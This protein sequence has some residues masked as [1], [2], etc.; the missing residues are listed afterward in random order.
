VIDLPT[1]QKK[2]NLHFSLTL[3]LFGN[4]IPTNAANAYAGVKGR[5][6][7]DKLSDDHQH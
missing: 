1:I 6:Q 2:L 4:E 3:D 5:F 7:E